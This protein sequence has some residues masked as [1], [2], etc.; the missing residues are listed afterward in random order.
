MEGIFKI[1]QEVV[2][3]SFV[4]LMLMK[5]FCTIWKGVGQGGWGDQN[6]YIWTEPSYKMSV[7][8][9]TLSGTSN[10]KRQIQDETPVYNDLSYKHLF[11][12][13]TFA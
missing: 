7:K 3:V 9:T 4:H 2:Q 10:K 8:L 12:N 5:Q 6:V 11:S 1:S 13:S